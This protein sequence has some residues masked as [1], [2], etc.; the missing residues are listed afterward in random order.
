MVVA[1][2]LA[3]VGVRSIEELD[4][5]E[6]ASELAATGNPRDGGSLVKQ[7]AGV[8]ELDTLLLDESHTQHLALLLIRNQLSGQHLPCHTRLGTLHVCHTCNGVLGS[9]I[10]LKHSMLCNYGRCSEYGVL[11]DEQGNRQSIILFPFWS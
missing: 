9:N 8:E 3:I 11:Q 7:E 1:Y 5:R 6:G 10:C 2:L 4:A